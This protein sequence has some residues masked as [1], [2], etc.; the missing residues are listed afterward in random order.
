MK[1]CKYCAWFKDGVCVNGESYNFADFVRDYDICEVYEEKEPEW[2]KELKLGSTSKTKK[3][4][5]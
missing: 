5:S 4:T 2:G 3:G 1:V